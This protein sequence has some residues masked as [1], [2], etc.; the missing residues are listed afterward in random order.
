MALARAEQEA[1][2]TVPGCRAGPCRTP[3]PFVL[4]E[5]SE[6]PPGCP[7][8]IELFDPRVDT[9]PFLSTAEVHITPRA[10]EAIAPLPGS[11]RTDNL[12]DLLA[13]G[14]LLLLETRVRH[15]IAG[16]GSGRRTVQPT[17]PT[18]VRPRPGT[19]TS[20]I[21]IKVV[22]DRSAEPL[23]GVNLRVTQPNGRTFDYTTRPD[24]CV[25]IHDID[26]GT[27][28]ATCSLE[29]ARLSDT[30]DFVTMGTQPGAAPAAAGTGPGGAAGAAGTAE[31]GGQPASSA[32][33]EQPAPRIRGVRI[34]EIEEHRVQT[35]E[36]LETLAA[37]AG[38][39]WQE[40][41]RFNWDTDDPDQINH[42]LR[43]DVG[44]TR[45]TA[46][47]RNYV[48][49]SSDDPGIVYIPRAWT[50]AGL[51][52]D[53]EHTVRVRSLGFRRAQ[54]ALVE[55]V[56]VPG[57]TFEFDKSYIRPS[58]VG[59]LAEVDRL[60]REHPQSRIIIFGH[61]DRVG[62]QQYNKDL[63][64]RRARSSFAFVTHDT[65]TW[66]QLYNEE[67]WGLRTVQQ[68]LL[69]L[70][71]DPGPIDGEMGPL[72]RGAMRSFL[73]LGA[74]APVNNDAAFRARLFGEYMRRHFPT[75]LPDARFAPPKFMG[76]GEFNP[77]D[78]PNAHELANRSPGNEPNRRV[79][80]YLFNRP[81][82][83][84]PCQLHSIGPCQA[85]IARPGTRNNPKLTCAF[86]DGI[87]SECRCEGGVRP[88][89]PPPPPPPTPPPP[90]VEQLTLTLTSPGIDD[91]RKVSHGAAVAVN[92]DHDCQQFQAAP[93]AAGRRELEPIFDLDH[94]AETPAEDDLL[95]IRLSLAP[96]GQAGNVRLRAVSG[97]NRIRVWPRSTKGAAGD[98]IA[99]PANLPANNLPP[100]LFVEGLQTGQ[101]TLEA[102]FTAGGQTVTDRLVI[103]VV[104]LV[105]TQG[106]ARKII[107]DYNSDIR[108]EVR[109]GPANYT[110][111]WD[112]DG[113]GAFGN[114]QA[115]QNRNTADETIRY[116]PAASANTIQLVENAAN[117]RSVFN[118]AVR[119]TGGLVLRVKGV[120]T[121]GGAT[122]SGIRVALGTHQGQPLPAMSTA[123]LHTLFAWSDVFPVRFDA[124]VPPDPTH[125][126]A[127]RISF[128]A[129][130]GANATTSFDGV[131][132]GRQVLF[133]EVGPG[134]WNRGEMR[135]DLVGT[136]N[137]EIRHLQQHASVRDDAPPGNVW[138]RLDDHFGGAAGYG[139]FRECEGHFSENQDTTISWF[140]LIAAGQRD[141]RQFHTRYNAALGVLATLP[142]GAARTAARQL[143]QDIYRNIPFFEMKRAG[144]D[145]SLRAPP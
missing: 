101:V 45:R 64:D 67:N 24:G 106:G 90:P 75:P 115:E 61:T 16:G 13:S 80:F 130:T 40:L 21:R 12:H 11:A 46:D 63:A 15:E 131:G 125:S 41:A 145:F 74:N 14:R 1:T 110:Y 124:L 79:V 81:P 99:L 23:A 31:D 139:D 5:A 114:A 65:G 92:N 84:P 39:T 121:E 134:I 30:Y 113:D 53:Q 60:A 26:P 19:Q 4:A 78:G 3:A 88:P 43:D 48:F 49:D 111:E 2:C 50:Q 54:P 133:V 76:C 34:A 82:A 72:T 94:L 8:V 117:R 85:E 86:Y 18:P 28:S 107:Y 142:A 122:R 109:G 98:V 55:C 128:D 93:G 73:G 66:E 47:G 95:E 89:P 52:T 69:D 38:I 62:S 112:F 104:E 137:H 140:H 143:L 103:N 56:C 70:G 129:A 108:F 123:G 71:H 126:G 9:V 118:V 37:G 141:L 58:V 68:T 51:A 35:G 97:G 87:A 116:G 136:V 7:N 135:E 27:C 6:V 25:E 36:T 83:A 32:P 42:H 77:I 20:W 119:L 132:A 144:Y 91:A 59:P 100:S 120:T 22:D 17:P 10:A 138:R 105:E 29:G 127:N 33:G 96:A 44:C 102:S 57:I